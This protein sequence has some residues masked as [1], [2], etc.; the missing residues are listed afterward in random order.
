MNEPFFLNLAI[1]LSLKLIEET[2]PFQAMNVTYSDSLP[3]SCT[4]HEFRSDEFWRC[5]IRERAHSWLHF[6]GTCKM[7]RVD[8]PM[9]VVDSKLR[10]VRECN[11]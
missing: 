4:N 1:K 8:D 7:G 5:F 11:D 2:S 3:V 9:A 10:F 6:T